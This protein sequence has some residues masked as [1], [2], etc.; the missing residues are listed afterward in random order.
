MSLQ[1]QPRQRS[2]HGPFDATA[3]GSDN[4]PERDISLRA[5]VA[6]GFEGMAMPDN[7]HETIAEQRLHSYLRSH[8]TQ[9]A[10]L[11]IGRPLAQRNRALLRFRGE[12]QAHERRHRR[13]SSDQRGGEGFD[14]PIVGANR[15]GATKAGDILWSRRGAKNRTGFMH[16]V[17]RALADLLRIGR[18]HHLAPGPHQQRIAG[19][20]AQTRERPAHRRGTEPQPA[21]GADDACVSQQR[22]E[23][24]QQV[25]VGDGFG[26]RPS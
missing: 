17:L 2:V 5:H 15:E 8:V 14:E 23:R 9:D 7:R 21:S 16:R 20:L 3:P 26:H 1:V 24:H 13:G 12:S 25:Q 6:I 4:V 18:Q 11:E 10:D 22:V 19:R